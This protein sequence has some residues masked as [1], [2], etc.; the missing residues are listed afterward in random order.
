MSM[1]DIVCMNIFISCC[2]S[3]V[4]THIILKGGEDK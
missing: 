3:F 2:V 1:L 4:V